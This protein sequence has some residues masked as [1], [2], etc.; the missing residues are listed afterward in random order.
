MID[1]LLIVV[2]YS[3]VELFLPYSNHF[4]L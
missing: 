3:T 2:R 1:M 4:V